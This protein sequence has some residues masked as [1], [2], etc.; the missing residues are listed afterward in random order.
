[1]EILPDIHQIPV[2]YK[3][4]PLKLYLLL[5][6][7]LRMLMDA[8][9][10]SVPDS[11]I[12]PYFEKI[13]LDP[14][15]LTHVMAT[16]PDVDHTGGLHRMKLA[17]PNAQFICGTLDRPQI[18]SPEGLV[19]IRMRAH[20][21]WHNMGM[22]DDAK[23]KF[24]PAPAD[25]SPSTPPSPAVKPSAATTTN[26]SKSST[27]RAIPTATS[28]STSPGKMPPSSATPSTVTPTASSTAAPRSPPPT[29]TS[30]NTS[31]PSTTSRQ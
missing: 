25:T 7:D 24:L 12:L 10:A 19:D 11:D 21:Y 27:S 3:G 18:E 9:D 2:N 6:P 29:C 22:D 8:G 30:T 16:H 26:T 5:A 23:T 14:K 17:A 28:A 1:M 15:S 13:N 20:Y 4:R 31:A